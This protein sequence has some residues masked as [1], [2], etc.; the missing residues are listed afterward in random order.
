MEPSNQTTTSQPRNLPQKWSQKNPEFWTDGNE[1]FSMASGLE[2]STFWRRA[3]MSLTWISDL[4]RW[5]PSR[6]MARCKF[7]GADDNWAD[8]AVLVLEQRGVVPSANSGKMMLMFG[9]V[10]LSSASQCFSNQPI[11]PGFQARWFKHPESF[12]FEMMFPFARYVCPTAKRC[13]QASGD[14]D[15]WPVQSFQ[16]C[17][18]GWP[19]ALRYVR[20]VY[21]GDSGWH[22]KWSRCFVCQEAFSCA[23][24]RCLWLDGACVPPTGCE[25]HHSASFILPIN[26]A[27]K[28][29]LSRQLTSTF[30]ELDD[31]F[32]RLIL[33]HMNF[34]TLWLKSNKFQAD[35]LHLKQCISK[36]DTIQ[37]M[38]LLQKCENTWKHL[39]VGAAPAPAPAPLA[40][41]A[42]SPALEWPRLVPERR[43]DVMRVLDARPPNL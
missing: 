31:P 41:L 12:F 13:F 25:V 16:G 10:G 1:A 18:G 39:S 2:Q 34:F 21:P 35:V 28:K 20:Y 43:S 36:L 4:I 26:D 29:L 8:S 3:C 33:N 22:R 23:Q 37:S 19:T 15:S 27:F 30:L 5:A 11:D 40:A 17:F 32:F 38:D 24:K 42:A 14:A 7:L 9:D 6:S